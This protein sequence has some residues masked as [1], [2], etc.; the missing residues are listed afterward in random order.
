MSSISGFLDAM[1]DDKEYDY[2]ANNYYQMSKEEL[3]DILL[4][5]I[6]AGHCCDK[7]VEDDIKEQVRDNLESQEIFG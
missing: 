4:E 3:K 6:Y 1:N 7:D 2:I 5:Y